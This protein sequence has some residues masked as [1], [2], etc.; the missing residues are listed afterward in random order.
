MNSRRHLRIRDCG[1]D[2]DRVYVSG[3]W[4]MPGVG[5][6]DSIAALSSRGRRR[7]GFVSLP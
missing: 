1:R 3:C 2:R 7:A 6:Q 4:V 5:G